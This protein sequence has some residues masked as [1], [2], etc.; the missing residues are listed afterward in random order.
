VSR[1]LP[2]AGLAVSLIVAAA[3]AGCGGGDQAVDHGSSGQGTHG[4]PGGSATTAAAATSSAAAFND[5]DAAFASDMIAHHEQAVEMASLVPRRST[6]TG[7]VELGAKIKAAQQPEIDLMSGWLSA[8]GVPA[9]DH[10]GH[11]MSG[12]MP[13]MMSA[14]DLEKLAG[15]RSAD[16]DRTFLTMM[17]AHHEGAITMANGQIADGRNADAVALANKVIADQTSEITQ[18]RGMLAM[19]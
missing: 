13:G 11:D 1:R 10:S 8:W 14:V 4:A 2:T 7:V 12:S 5:S 15:L 18:M 9:E 16:F 17:I 3:L 6:N 19:L